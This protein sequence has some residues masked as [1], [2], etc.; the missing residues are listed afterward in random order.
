MLDRVTPAAGVNV[1]VAETISRVVAYPT[2]IKLKPPVVRCTV[3]LVI[4]GA[5]LAMV[6]VG[7]GVDEGVMSMPAAVSF[8]VRVMVPDTVGVCMRE[9]AGKTTWVVLADT[10]KLAVRLPRVGSHAFGSSGLP[11]SGVKVMMI[12]PV[13]S[14]GYAFPMLIPRACCVAGATV[15]GAPVIAPVK[16][17]GGASG[18]PT[19]M[20]NGF[21]AVW[22][23]SVT[24][25]VNVNAPGAVGVP[26]SEPA[27][28]FSVIPPGSV[29][30]EIDQVNVPFP[31]AATSGWLYAVPTVPLSSVAVV[32]VNAAVTVMV[33][34]AV[35]VR[36]AASAAWSVKLN[37]PAAVGVPV[38]LPAAELSV[39]PVGN[40]PVETDH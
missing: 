6:R 22:P 8:K 35:V 10:V 15:A 4:F 5:L 25:T 19:V 1:T 23:P 20:V 28:A 37:V 27:D 16:V 12:C 3:A 26:P 33:N 34:D 40:E 32:M 2:T 21:V 14:S 13:I 18:T 9:P 30:V 38:R 29:P 7:D 11:E 39:S 24:L 36:P 17:T 31:P